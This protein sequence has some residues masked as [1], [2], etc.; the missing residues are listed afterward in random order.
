MTDYDEQAKPLPK[1]RGPK[2]KY[3]SWMADKIIEVAEGGG[4]H[5]A[6]MVELGI[7][8]DTFYRWKREI[9]EFKEAC[10]QADLVSLALQERMLVQG[11]LGQI[12][13]FNFSA[14]AMVLNN[15]YKAQY[16]RTGNETNVSITNNTLNVSSD[17][18]RNKIAQ[19]LELIK[20]KG[21]ELTPQGMLENVKRESD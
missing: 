10:E 5:A 7:T 15:K 14:V 3:E 4:F 6:M 19:K 9:P 16:Q 18:V 11:A 17:E 2:N 13:N 12:K 20:S 8:N 1:R 21:V